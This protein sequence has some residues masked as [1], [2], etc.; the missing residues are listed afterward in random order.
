MEF[1]G[2]PPR[3]LIP[4]LDKVF[5]ILESMKTSYEQA[6]NLVVVDDYYDVLIA[7]ERTQEIKQRLEAIIQRQQGF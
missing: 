2:N 5:E 1:S 3:L 4:Y 6:N 7:L